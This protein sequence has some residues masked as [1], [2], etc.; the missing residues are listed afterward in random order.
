MRCRKLNLVLV[1]LVVVGIAM[2][3]VGAGEGKISTRMD[4]DLHGFFIRDFEG[5]GK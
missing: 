3:L 2:G 5:G 4:T 1:S